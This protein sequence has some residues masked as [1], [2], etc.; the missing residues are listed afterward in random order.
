MNVRFLSS[1]DRIRTTVNVLGDSIGAGIVAH[2][3][4][5]DLLEMDVVQDLVVG[6]EDIDNEHSGKA[7]ETSTML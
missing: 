1:R 2:L 7:E 3:S 5:R 4:R 6:P